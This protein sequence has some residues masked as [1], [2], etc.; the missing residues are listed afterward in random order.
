MA[1]ERQGA[2]TLKGNALTLVGSE[3]KVGDQAPDFTVLEGLGAEVK[4]GDLGSK[5]KVF[6]VVLSIDTPVCDAQTQRFNSETANLPEDLE[7]LTV[8][9]DLPFA[10]KRYCGAAGID[11]VR[12]VSDYRD[13]SFGAAYGVLIK[14]HRLLCRAIFVVDK[15]NV[16]RYVEYVPEITDH[17]DYDGALEAIKALG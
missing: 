5:I 1:D 10:A 4:L 16:V 8:S 6:N 17:P 15:D 13:A 3:I 9:M 2:V 14:E 7:I 11:S 12:V